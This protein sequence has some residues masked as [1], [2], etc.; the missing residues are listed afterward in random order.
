MIVFLKIHRKSYTIDAEK[1]LELEKRMRFQ[2]Y[3]QSKASLLKK[4]K[5]MGTNTKE[6]DRKLVFE[7]IRT[8]HPSRIIDNQRPIYS[9]EADSKSSSAYTHH[10]R[11]SNSSSSV[12]SSEGN[13]EDSI[14]L[15]KEIRNN[16]VHVYSS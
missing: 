16:H 10:R 13:P 5:P 3:S 9:K 14:M 4:K 2:P 1:I 11:S 8:S 7:N 6:V 15:E 12:G